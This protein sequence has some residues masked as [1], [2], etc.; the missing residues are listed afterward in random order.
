MRS[1]TGVKLEVDLEEE[2][3]MIILII[4]IVTSE[5]LLA[6]MEALTLC[7][8]PM[9]TL[10][11]IDKSLLIR[12]NLDGNSSYLDKKLYLA[13]LEMKGELPDI[14]TALSLSLKML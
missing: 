9:R 13:V 6:R 5:R 14:I 2:F 1:S 12:E 4:L 7:L 10:L 11:D 3:I 8:L